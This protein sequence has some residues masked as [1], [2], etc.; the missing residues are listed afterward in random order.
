MKKIKL[1]ENFPPTFLT[2]FQN[3]LI[4]ASSVYLQN[5]SGSDDNLIYNVCREEERTLIT[6]DVDFANIIR[7]PAEETSGIIVC[8]IRKK[9]DLA[10]I[11]ELCV[12][13]VKIISE[14]DLNGKLFIVEENR[15]RIRKP[16]EGDSET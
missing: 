5:L 11:R 13:L 10:Y 1:D 8:R 6:F 16:D 15:V 7:Y 2:L 12:I 4:D 14:N 3:D 9:I